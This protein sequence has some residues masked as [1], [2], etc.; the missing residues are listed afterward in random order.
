M[1][2]STGPKPPH[3]D[4]GPDAAEAAGFGGITWADEA[5]DEPKPQSAAFEPEEGE[6]LSFG[7]GDLDD[8]ADDESDGQ[9]EADDGSP[10]PDES[11]DPAAASPGEHA[12]EAPETSVDDLVGDL[13]RVTAERD[14]YLDASRRL[15]AEFENYRKA[16][17][18]READTR[19][20]AN[21]SLIVEILPVLDACDGALASGASDVE[22]VRSALVDVLTKQGLERIEGQDTPFD[23]VRHDAV[24]HE[25]DE[26]GEGPVVAE[27]MRPGYSWKGRVVRPA[28]V[29][30]RG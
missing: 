5:S 24:M 11:A 21:E 7:Q 16:V 15:Q 27:V 30:V 14:Q 4:D 28:M 25:P 3:L 19:E 2:G 6:D 8:T 18:K 9:P 22:P 17:S 20:R 1:S 12:G 26:D 13:E 10:P 23:P 29:R